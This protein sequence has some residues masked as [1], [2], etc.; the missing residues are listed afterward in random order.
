MP[1]PNPCQNRDCPKDQWTDVCDDRC[2]KLASD[3]IDYCKW[4]QAKPPREPKFNTV[5][6]LIASKQIAIIT[7]MDE[8]GEFVWITGRRYETAKD[9]FKDWQEY[10]NNDNA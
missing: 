5:Y 8:S 6:R 1:R 3:T 4:Y 9:F 2:R 10:E 7:T